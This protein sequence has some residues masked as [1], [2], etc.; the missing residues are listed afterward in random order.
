MRRF[1]DVVRCGEQGPK[2][3]E[4][5]RT[6]LL[7]YTLGSGIWPPFSSPRALLAFQGLNVLFARS[8]VYGQAIIP[9]YVDG[10]VVQQHGRGFREDSKFRESEA[11]SPVRSLVDYGKR[12]KTVECSRRQKERLSLEQL[13][14][15]S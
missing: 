11:G 12:G 9:R 10:T 1:H 14:M 5:R 8:V 6:F 3:G 2:G 7:G 15:K 13:G 4:A